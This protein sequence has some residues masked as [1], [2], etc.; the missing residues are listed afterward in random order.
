[1]N[2]RLNGLRQK[3]TEAGIDALLI[4][5]QKDRRYLSGFSSTAGYLIISQDDAILALDSRYVE[6]ARQDASP[7]SEISI[8]N[9]KGEIHNWLPDIIS[10][11][12]ISKLGFDDTGITYS[13]YSKMNIALDSVEK[14]VELVATGDMVTGLRTIK[15]AQE[16]ESMQ[17]AAA[18]ADASF[19]SMNQQI[20][21]GM[22]EKELA[23]L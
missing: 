5:Q 20:K 13:T 3:M 2:Q 12:G 21:I 10:G 14:A 8:I 18:V 15:D 17:K 4:S 9:T 11:M 22:S 6:W 19:E 7:T 16:L 23:W 1:M